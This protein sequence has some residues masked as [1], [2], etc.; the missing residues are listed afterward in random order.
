MH[1]AYI[2]C[3]ITHL[4]GTLD[5]QVLYLLHHV[6]VCVVKGAEQLRGSTGLLARPAWFTSGVMSWAGEGFGEAC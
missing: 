3:K 2:V 6:D 1:I 4:I 5:I